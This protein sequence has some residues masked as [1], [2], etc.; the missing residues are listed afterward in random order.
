MK[1]IAAFIARVIALAV[2]FSIISC[3]G[4]GGDDSTGLLSP[5]RGISGKWEG[6]LISSDNS[7]GGWFLTNY[8][9]ALDLTHKDNSVT[10]TIVLTSKS[11]SKI[12]TGWPTPTMNQTYT[13]SLSGTVSGVNVDFTTTGSNGSCLHF[14]GTFTSD[15]MTGMINPADPPMLTCGAVLNSAT[16]G[17]KGVEWHL[18]KK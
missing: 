16:G 6:N 8:D 9:M 18:S 5:A 11:V 17:V 2:A 12:P 13:G 15:I 3:G 7:A 10:G 1:T 14:K 4:G